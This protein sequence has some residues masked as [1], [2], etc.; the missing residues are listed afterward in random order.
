MAYRA[1]EKLI[2]LHDGYRRVFRHDNA[3]LLLLQ[4]HGEVR[5]I[6]RH[7]PHAGQRL[8]SAAVAGAVITCPRHQICF[9]LEDGRPG[10]ADCPA[11]GIRTLVYEGNSLGI[12]A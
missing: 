9:S 12:D 3:E 1:L 6:D 10:N 4:E 5:L 11:L 8:D 7:C 2:N